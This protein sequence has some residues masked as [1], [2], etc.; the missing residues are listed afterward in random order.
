MK[1]VMLLGRLDI[2]WVNSGVRVAV[3]LID[4]QIAKYDIT[5][6]LHNFYRAMH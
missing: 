2:S 1:A 4:S 5:I 6:N 3:K